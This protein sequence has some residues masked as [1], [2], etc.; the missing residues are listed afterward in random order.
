M[1]KKNEKEKYK[2]SSFLNSLNEITIDITSLSDILPENSNHGLCGSKNL[3]N[4]CYMNSSIACL[5]NCTELTTFFLSKEFRKYINSS[6]KNG[7]KGKLANAWYELLKEYWKTTKLTGNPREIQTLIGKKYKKFDSDD[8]QDANEFIVLFLELLG[9]DLNEI[10]N[11]KYLELKEQQHQETDEEC[12]KRFW[13]L[14]LSRNNS[15]ITNLFCGLNKSIIKCPLCKYKSIT[16]NPFTSISLLIPNNKQLKT[17]KYL[18]YSKEDIFLYYIPRLC[19]GKTYKIYIR[20]EKGISFKEILSQIQK[21][22]D[23]PYEISKVDIISVINKELNNIIKADQIYDEINKNKNTFYF[24]IEKDFFKNKEMIFIPIYI[25]L[26]DKYSAYP[27]GLYVFPGMSYKLF[28]KKMYFLAR[29]YIYHLSSN[30]KNFEVDKKITNIIFDYN[31]DEEQ[32]LLELIEKEY[33]VL[34]KHNYDET[35][36]FPYN[37]LIQKNI[38]SEIS[39]IFF[40]GK[41]DFFENLNKY[42]ITSKESPIDLLI[43]D[44]QN[45]N[46]ILIINININSK[47]FRK[48]IAKGI[49]VC[50]SITSDDYC[51]N[52]YIKEANITLEDCFQL[53]N[54]EENLDV[55]NEWFCKICKNHVK[56]KKKLEFFYLPKIMCICLS[57]FKKI[58]DEYTKN[59]KFVDFPLENLNMNKFMAFNDGKKYIYD[60]FAVNE[61]YGGREGGHYTAICKNYDGNWYSYDDSNCSISSKRDICTRNAYIL[62]YRRRDW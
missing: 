56:A 55:G 44:L 12:A 53:F 60:I 37:L 54:L 27:R 47:Y 10:K 50:N 31:K 6:N 35:I 51:K 46:N 18:N 45:L 25:K 59:E 2:S 15:I 30:I 1:E 21:V 13:D 23:F 24:A 36:I 5:S 61:H 3:G 19:L 62:F 49:D 28:Q 16:Y 8:Q 41:E 42:Q 39:T 14:H 33:K 57:R 20:V 11:K 29:K 7:L 48:S 43:K 38:Y 4:T 26:G 9:E 40:D 58:G 17:V 22:D 32:I 34:L 52:D